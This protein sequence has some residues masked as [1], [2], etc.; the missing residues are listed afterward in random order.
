M[1]KPN[2]RARTSISR[3][4][5]VVGDSI[6]VMLEK[7]MEG[8]GEGAI[9]DRDLV[10]NENMSDSVNPLTNIRSDKMEMLLEQKIDEQ[11]YLRRKMTV[12]KEEIKEPPTENNAE[13][14]EIKEAK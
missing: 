10:Y 5:S 14:G 6:E 1:K 13:T 4:T 7:L 3:N 9:E 8:E 12:K 11:D 2:K